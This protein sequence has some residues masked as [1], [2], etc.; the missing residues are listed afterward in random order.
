MATLIIL[1]TLEIWIHARKHQI[2]IAK[3]KAA[4]KTNRMPASKIKS[5]LPSAYLASPSNEW[6]SIDS[7]MKDYLLQNLTKEEL[8]KLDYPTLKALIVKAKKHA[9]DG[10][11]TQFD[12]GR[13]DS[14]NSYR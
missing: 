6:C 10:T 8:R 14:A 3:Q 12:Y 11:Y 4:Y 7:T 13:S 5:T 9:K 1:I 2:V